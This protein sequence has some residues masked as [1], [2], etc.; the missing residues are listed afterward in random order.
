[1]AIKMSLDLQA[2]P[3]IDGHCHPPIRR[4]PRSEAEL[5]A[6]FTESRDTRIVSDHVQHTLFW[7]DSIR[8]L[9][10][11]FDMEQDSALQ[12]VLAHRDSYSP[13]AYTAR[14]VE[15]AGIK[16]LV[17]DYGYR[18]SEAYGHDEMQNAL[19]DTSCQVKH[20]LRLEPLIEELLVGSESFEGLVDSFA[21]ELSELRE[22]GVTALKSIIGYRAGLDVQRV[23]EGE[24]RD[25]YASIREKVEDSR[26]SLRISSK[27]LLN[28]LILVA[29]EKAAEQSVPVQFHTAL[30][31]T[32]IDLVQGNPLLL[33]N[34]ME[35]QAFREAPI[36]LLHCYPYLRE[37]A[38]LSN[39][40]GNVYVDLSMTL[41]VLSHTS[42]RALEDVLG[43]A[44]SSK[45]L[46]GS[47]APGIPDFL[48]LGAV[49]WRRA[50]GQ[51][52]N[53]WVEDGMRETQ[54]QSIAEQVLYKNSAA[55]YGVTD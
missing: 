9:A 1:M 20:V 4:Q 33:R 40:Y 43:F 14:I 51:L 35:E 29:L 48:W 3:L 54:A 32:D 6:Y 53:S 31:D 5:K 44:P 52:L 19:R 16:G 21:D 26:E 11:L 23:S 13:G 24:A 42:V 55:L 27:P 15:R 12:E 7:Q 36:V 22:K 10:D 50:L 18:S 34:I 8:Q 2:I 46:Y 39:M 17:M 49:T 41:P 45:V 47:D 30:G 28:Y 25:A 37:A 38:Y